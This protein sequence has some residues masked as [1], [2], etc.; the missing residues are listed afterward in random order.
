MEKRAET[1]GRGIIRLAREAGERSQRTGDIHDLDAAV[2]AWQAAVD[3][4]GRGEVNVAGRAE[5]L[6]E[7]AGALLRR[8]QVTRSGAGDLAKAGWWVQEAIAATPGDAPERLLYLSNAGVI[9]QERYAA[10]GDAT[11]LEQ[12]VTHLHSAA[13]PDSPAYT[14][15]TQHTTNL[16]PALAAPLPPLTGAP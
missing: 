16:R 4:A 13:H 3:A 10:T 14:V 8:Y 1:S 15:P 2:A 6:S 7:A 11:M 9:C 12:A 5:I